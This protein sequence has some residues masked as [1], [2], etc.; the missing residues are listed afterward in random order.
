MSNNLEKNWKVVS[1]GLIYQDNKV[2]LGLRPNQETDI[3]EFPGGSIE[4]GELP[5]QAMQRELK[6]ELNIDVEDWSLAD[7]LT[8]YRKQQAYIIVLYHVNKWQGSIKNQVHTKLR[9]LSLKQCQQE[10]LPNINPK[11]FSK[12]QTLLAKKIK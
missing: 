12:I 2:L 9:W 4:I 10:M 5:E 1:V 3:W 6:E 8:D 11:L 7:C